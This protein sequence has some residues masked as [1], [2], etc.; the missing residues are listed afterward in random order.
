ML[1]LSKKDI[2][3]VLEDLINYCEGAI[4]AATAGDYLHNFAFI[5]QEKIRALRAEIDASDMK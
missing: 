3:C 4:M 5:M 2:C 1:N